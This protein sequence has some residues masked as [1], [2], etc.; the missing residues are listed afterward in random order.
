MPLK[1]E[2][3]GKLDNSSVLVYV[4]D[5]APEVVVEDTEPVKYNPV[6]IVNWED[7]RTQLI[8]DGNTIDEPSIE[9]KEWYN[10]LWWYSDKSCENKFDFDSS[11]TRDITIYACRKAIYTVSF[12]KNYYW[13]EDEW[14]SLW[15]VQAE[16]WTT[17]T[18][19]SDPEREDYN[20]LWWA[21][22]D[23]C[24][25]IIDFSE[26]EIKEN[27]T[28]YACWE[29]L[30]SFFV[31][32]FDEDWN[33]LDTQKI[34]VG[35]TAVPY[36]TTNE[37]WCKAIWQRD[38]EEYD[39]STPVTEDIELHVVWD[40][41]NKVEQVQKVEH[42]T[43]EE[44]TWDNTQWWSS[45]NETIQEITY[46]AEEITWEVTY[47]GV[48]VSVV[49]PIGT[50]P[51]NTELVIK[52]IETIKEIK[53]VQDALVEQVEEIDNSTFMV[54]FDISFLDPETKEELQPSNDKTVEVTFNYEENDKLKEAEENEEKD[55][56]VYHM[57]ED[58]VEWEITVQ[59]T[60]VVNNELTWEVTVLTDSFSVYTV[61]I[62]IVTD[63][64]TFEWRKQLKDWTANDLE[65]YFLSTNDAV[66]HYTIMDRNLWASTWYN[67]NWS[68][69][70][71]DSFWYH[72]QWWNNYWF[73]S[74]LAN[75]C[76]TFPWWESSN[77]SRVAKSIW[78]N[79]IPSEY[80]RNIWD[81]N[82]SYYNW[83]ID[84]STTDWIWWWTWDTTSVNGE[85]TTKEWRQWPCPEWYYIPS[86]KDWKDMY[87]AWYASKSSTSNI[88]QQ[89][90]SDWLMPAAG[91]RYTNKTV[92]VLVLTVTTG[93]LLLSR[94]VQVTPAAFT[95]MRRILVLRI[96]ATV[97][98]VVLSAALRIPPTPK[99]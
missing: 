95:S 8:E 28:A 63:A 81:S 25:N 56:V 98:T 21:R 53:K 85:G 33:E 97:L 78:S 92:N 6:K 76:N 91:Y 14:T 50:F 44:W 18:P 52:P 41:N 22:E 17:I 34:D 47:A 65:L 58:K 82:T 36:M 69:P 27:F 2:G 40:C 12:D 94:V 20:F 35:N 79:Y 10:F 61:A 66:T 59:E 72:Y 49:A 93:R 87:D 75:N 5:D 96:T 62:K 84:S 71:T 90:S 68:S 74:C 9:E 77:T 23:E 73:Q 19:V 26:K 31:K 11:I 70:N 55:I 67:Q 83:M 4:V 45:S 51:E 60:S 24:K 39:F 89:I 46:N 3:G 32:S 57:D 43:A 38:W 30:P 64:T 88:W 1:N 13:E 80:G 99:L 16:E 42:E 48:T 29:E 7:E 86:T 15:E 37:S 54:S